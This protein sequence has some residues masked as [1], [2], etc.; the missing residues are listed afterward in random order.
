VCVVKQ[1]LYQINN[2]CLRFAQQNYLVVLYGT[3]LNRLT[4]AYTDS[5][6]TNSF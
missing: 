5:G 6:C 4:H 3:D 2:L 1:M